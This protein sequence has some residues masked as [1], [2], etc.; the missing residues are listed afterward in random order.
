MP[1][2][3]Q[4]DRWHAC[5]LSKPG[6]RIGV[7]LRPR[8]AAELVDHHLAETCVVCRTCRQPFRRPAGCAAGEADEEQATEADGEEE[9]DAVTKASAAPDYGVT[10]MSFQV[11]SP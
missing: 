9:V 5:L 11:G 8:R 1:S 2:I 6:E 3:M 7:P 10:L 4:A